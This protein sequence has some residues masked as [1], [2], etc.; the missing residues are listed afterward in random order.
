MKN[1][2]KESRFACMSIIAEP[3]LA[4]ATARG[5]S[6]VAYYMCFKFNAN[7]TLGMQPTIEMLLFAHADAATPLEK[8][9]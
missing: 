5:I 3:G 2:Q 8:A 6:H 9:T 1:K 7:L 4:R